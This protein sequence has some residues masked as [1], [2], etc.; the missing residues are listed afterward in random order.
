MDRFCAIGVLRDVSY[1]MSASTGF[2]AR[3][4]K[5]RRQQ[6]RRQR[7]A[8]LLLMLLLVVLVGMGLF[9]SSLN[10]FS[11]AAQQA[12]EA[13]TQ[14]AL[15]E[16]KA[17]LI[18][19][20]TM[21]NL[22]GQLPCPEDTS[23][24]GLP[25]EGSARSS[26]NTG[27]VL[28]R[29]PWK[30]LGLP[31]LRDDAG[32]PL[33]YAL[34]PG[35]RLAP[36]NSDTP[37]QL[38]VDGVGQSAVA[39]IIAPG[40]S[41]AGQ[42]RAPVTATQPPDPAQYLEGGNGSGQGRLVSL[43][44]A[45]AFNDRI[46]TISQQELFSAVEKRVA[47]EVLNELSRFFD[48]YHYYPRPAALDDISCLGEGSL[49]GECPSSSA[50]NF[51]RLPATPADAWPFFL[52]TAQGSGSSSRVRW[53]RPNGW[54]NLI[55]YA[56]ADACADGTSSCNGAGFLTVNY[57]RVPSKTSQ[58]VVVITAGKT[59]ASQLREL[60]TEKIQIGNYLENR[61]LTPESKVFTIP[62]KSGQA[63]NDQLFTHP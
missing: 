15:L 59:L 30:T 42:K 18:G 21:N 20:A 32:E 63:F 51:G 46:M 36:I 8:A 24:I 57:P 35:F 5:A 43:G 25:N 50:G 62:S 54:Q 27:F 19:W 40:A 6:A 1:A 58:K 29:L 48:A 9:V 2:T 47:G 7:G 33:W 53:F 44:D 60:N 16:A 49:S 61:S 26:C 4:E 13:Q 11:A 22:P 17:A 56:V 12:A 38:S 10:R 23:L 45:E 39:V 52:S 14:G 34:S 3:C 28:G 31:K 37:A 41:L 55:F